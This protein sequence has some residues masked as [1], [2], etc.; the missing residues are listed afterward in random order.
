MT[1]SLIYSNIRVYR[2]VMNA[3]YG[4]KYRR[5]F[6]RIV[7]LVGPDSGSMCEL[8]FGD[9]HIGRWCRDRA[10]RWTGVDIN[11]YFCR[12]A[13]DLGFHVIRGDPLEVALPDADVFVMAGSLYHFH[14]RIE[15]LLEAIFTHTRR[16]IL[17]EPIRNLSSHGGIVGRL[18]RRSANPGVGEADFRFD[19]HSLLAALAPHRER[20]GL[21]VRRVS[22]DRDLLLEITR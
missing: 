13:R 18:A 20:L 19:E 21:Q 17:S 14:T 16:F 6:L 22:C 3:L 11:P 5:R 15:S 4:G 12:R 9:T 7:D 2:L 1:R 8:C 10:V